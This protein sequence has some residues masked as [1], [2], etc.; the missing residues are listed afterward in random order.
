[1]NLIAVILDLYILAHSA[2]WFLVARG[3]QNN[4]LT[5]FIRGI[6]APLNQVLSQNIQVVIRG[7]PVVPS[8]LSIISIAL[9]RLSLSAL[10][11]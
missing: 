11:H 7:T 9:V 5:R 10:F 3:I 8:A 2:D 4:S 6:C 1:M